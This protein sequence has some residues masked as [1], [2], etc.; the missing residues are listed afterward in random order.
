MQIITVI[1]ATYNEFHSALYVDGSNILLYE[2]RLKTADAKSVP[3]VFIKVNT[4]I[5]IIGTTTNM[6]SQTK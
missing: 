2:S 1:P 4:N 6:M 5:T 3:F